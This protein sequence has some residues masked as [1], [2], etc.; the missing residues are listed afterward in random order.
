[1]TDA[2]AGVSSEVYRVRGIEE[3]YDTTKE[4]MV[5]GQR[6]GLGGGGEQVFNESGEATGQWY[7]RGWS[8]GRPGREG[9]A[10]RHSD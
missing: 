5:V 9:D 1:M 8:H 10:G 3:T 2:R 7:Q 6:V 4:P